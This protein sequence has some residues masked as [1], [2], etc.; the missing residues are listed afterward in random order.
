MKREDAAFGI[1]SMCHFH[2]WFKIFKSDLSSYFSKGEMFS[3]CY[4]ALIVNRAGG[5]YGRLLI[6]GV[7]TWRRSRIF[8]TDCLSSIMII[9]RLLYSKQ[10]QFYL[11]HY[12]VCTNWHFANERRRTEFNSAKVCSRLISFSFFFWFLIRL[13]GSSIN[14]YC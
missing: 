8:H 14:E 11:F 4:L 2:A 7:E 13:F 1:I 5:L 10:D 9:R 3:G 12:L 6:E